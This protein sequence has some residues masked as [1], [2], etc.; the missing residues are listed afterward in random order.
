MRA[1]EHSL[2]DEIERILARH[3]VAP[4]WL[5][6][7]ITESVL[8]NSFAWIVEKLHRLRALG[9]S[10]AL[11]DFGTGYSS[12]AYLQHL[13]I[14]TLKIDRSFV[15]NAANLPKQAA[16]LGAIVHMAAELGL[17]TVAEGVETPAD[18]AVLKNLNCRVAQGYYYS[19]PLTADAFLDWMITRTANASV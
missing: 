16:L 14:T 13:P 15:D 5:E 17:T 6:I 1:K 8:L 9:V 7:E 2:V 18:I 12:L 11:D 19:R 10:V 3:A 4:Q